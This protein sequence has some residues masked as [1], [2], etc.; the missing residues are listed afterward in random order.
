MAQRNPP[1]RA[2]RWHRRAPAVLLCLLA[3]RVAAAAGV[4]V[5][6]HGVDENLKAN[7]LAYLSF[8]RYR[9]G[10]AELS[11]DTVERLHER[12]EREVQAAL[13]PYGYY[14][15]QVDS[16]VTEVSHNE[17]RVDVNINPGKPVLLDDVDVR[18]S[19]PGSNDPLFERIVARRPRVG[20]R[21]SHVD[22]EALKTDL[23]RTAATY[24]YLDAKLTRNE[25]IVDPPN[26]K[27]S[28][29]L[30]MQTGERY[31]FGA[32]TITQD[33][34]KEPLVRRF[35]R[36]HQGEPFDL[37]QVLRTQ[38]AL[39]DAQYFVN[40]EVQPGEPDRAAHLVPITIRANARRKNRYSLAPGY[41]TDT[42]VRVT[43]GFEDRLV[44]RE[45]HSLGVEMQFSQ[46]SRYNVQ[47]RY[48]VPVLDP[49]LDSLALRAQIQ[50]QTL[51]DVTAYT[52][53][54]GPS[55]TMVSGNWQTV[56]SVNAVHT[57]SETIISTQTD[58]LLVPELD[59]ATVP[60]GYLGEPLF[61]HPFFAEIKGSSSA[62]G[63]D[64][65][66]LQAHLTGERVFQVYPGWHLLLRDE[67][68]ATF[69]SDFSKL[70]AIYRFFAGGDNSVRGF[71]YNELSPTTPVCEQGTNTT[72]IACAT[73]APPGQTMTGTIKTGGKDLITGTVEVVRDLPR[74]LGV[75]VFFDYGN[76]FDHFGTQLYY[77]AGIGLR[78]R[79]PV[80]TL[81]VDVAQP[82]NMPGAGPRL[83]I[84][85]SPKL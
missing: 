30:E 24:G 85:F 40:L 68:G 28:V 60:P 2:C 78:V 75:A 65:N 47:A 83:H 17:W 21:L 6:V 38:F 81:G 12:V 64:S 39:D 70:P 76:A 51:A 58:R 53:A 20:E 52:Q 31:R 33:A 26:H 19:G 73:P 34:V 54:L 44:N 18:V 48:A 55:L 3:W 32:T 13:R 9:K 10:G 1:P 36:Y 66:F 43:A 67:V 71:Y 4:S 46:V 74:N 50:Q 16:T 27:A 11:A 7:V 41:A 84:N 14:E 42:G 5:E 57:T 8:E 79:L 22:Y 15:P 72:P 45:G 23:L 37:T 63:S 61:E 62:L 56:W 29:V 82:L 59:L 77:S 80:M 25:L 49:A 69:V 35:L